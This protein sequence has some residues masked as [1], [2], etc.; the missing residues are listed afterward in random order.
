MKVKCLFTA[1]L[2]LISFQISFAQAIEKST[3]L[4]GGTLEIRGILPDKGPNTFAVD[5]NPVVG[6]FI[7]DN[8]AVGPGFNL[9]F[10]NTSETNTRSF[11]I[12][13]SPLVRYYL[14]SETWKV[15]GQGTVGYNWV[16]IDSN[17]ESTNDSFF[18]AG[19]GIGMAMFPVRSVG[20]EMSVN[21]LR[22]PRFSEGVD[23]IMFRVGI[24][25]YKRPK[26]N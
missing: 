6:L 15:F 23:A 4:M 25:A 24:F 16:D 8:L 22:N 17:E 19:V 14:G 9:A 26:G 3:K 20:L 11:K 5:L 1:V 12:G 21:Y 18:N 7:V 10:A 13:V 2:L